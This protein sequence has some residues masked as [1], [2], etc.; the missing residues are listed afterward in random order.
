MVNPVLSVED[1]E[2][3]YYTRQGQLPALHDITF[4]V[5]QG[6]IVGLVG[7]SGCGK[8]TVAC[9]L[10]RLLPPNGEI[11][12]GK[13][14]LHEKDI[15][16]FEKNELQQLRGS[17]VAMIFQD[18]M[19]SLNP[20]FPVW[21]QMYDALL[22][23]HFKSGDSGMSM[24]ER[25]IAL[26]DRLG[27]PDPSRQIDSFPHEFSGGMRQRIMIAMALM[28][29]PAL[30][31]ADEPTSAL[32]V[33]L[34]AQILQLIKGLQKD[35]DTS[36]LYITHDLGVVAQVCDHV[37][38]MY[39]GRIV[40]RQGVFGLFENPVHPY[41]QAL[42]AAVPS[43]HRRGQPL[44]TIPGR[45]PGLANLP[46][47]CK[48]ADRCSIAKQICHVEE[49]AFSM[50]KGAGVRCH[51]RN[52]D[53]TYRKATQVS[54]NSLNPEPADQKKE[55]E[56]NSP[57]D[58][59]THDKR[60]TNGN[61]VELRNVTTRFMDRCGI[62]KRMQGCKPGSVRAV[63]HVNIAIRT[64]EVLGLVGESGSGKTTLGRTILQM[65]PSFAGQIFFEGHE[66]TG[67]HTKRINRLRRNMQ[68]IFQDPVSSLSP[69][70]RVSKLLREPYRIHNVSRENRRDVYDL[71]E[72]VG[73]SREQAD[74]FP[75]ELSGGQARRVSIARA[76]ALQPKFLI[77]DE[78]TA[79]LDVSVAASILNLM[80]DLSQDLGLTYLIITHNLN[81]L[82]YVADRIAVMYLGKIIEI[83]STDQI[84]DSHV[85]PYTL[86]LLSAVSEPDPH[87]RGKKR[88]F[89]LTGE[90]P[91]PRNP[92]SGCVFHPRCAF[93]EK[94]CSAEAP[95]LRTIADNHLAACH[96]YERV[97]ELHS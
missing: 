14:L 93:G 18:P 36:I 51:A 89:I 47:G 55:S 34:E 74:K 30:L 19:T 48:F 9:S 31:I 50:Y 83:G 70:L 26:L 85:H 32:D 43:R 10:M 6:E 90:I 21:T 22:S 75:H 96:F 37:V 45:V 56:S 44:E 57:G 5:G 42:L 61:L 38:V 68:M 2:V 33:T 12:S 58:R 15:L 54:L 4:E 11:T 65:V 28:M 63:D 39:A 41:T 77:A 80:D 16:K 49:P 62:I 84:F 53:S 81:V 87:N 23:H 27:L 69:R 88:R 78:P 1:L 13:V 25:A 82:G 91:S 73:L 79:G 67:P 20:V 7:E 17:D 95:E 92:P 72:M 3:C 64:G 59:G 76:L 66:I 86:A 71:L 24:R 94:R 52:P 35:F 97:Q 60:S 29:R 46:S 8:S 40:E